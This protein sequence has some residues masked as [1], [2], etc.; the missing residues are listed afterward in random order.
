MRLNA[1]TVIELIFVIVI[2]GILAS[3]GVPKLSGMSE[4]AKKTTEIA[5]F[6]AITTALEAAHGDWV[7]NEG[8]FTWGIN[9][10]SSTLDPRSGYPFDLNSTT[11]VFGKILKGDTQEFTT[12]LKGADFDTP[13]YNITLFT[14]PASDPQKGVK[15]PNI[16]VPGKPDKNDYWVYASFVTTDKNCSIDGKPFS[17][18]DIF[19]VDDV[20]TQVRQTYNPTITCN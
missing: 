18:G 12:R 20:S 3:I 8:S 1:F 16:D 5:T 14:G 17:S 15:L 2:I 11:K 13:D 7:I 10:P 6:S 4:N 19:L 9:Q